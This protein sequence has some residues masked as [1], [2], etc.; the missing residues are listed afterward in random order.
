MGRDNCLV[1]GRHASNHTSRNWNCDVREKCRQLIYQDCWHKSFGHGSGRW[2]GCGNTLIIRVLTDYTV[3]GPTMTD[4]RGN[5]YVRDRTAANT[6]TTIRASIFHAVI[7]TPLQAGDTITV[8]T[9]SVAARVMVVDEF[10]SVLTPTVIDQ[11]NGASAT[12]ASPSVSVTTTN[13]NDLL[14]GFCGVEGASTDSYDDDP[15]WFSLVRTGTVGGTS[16]SNKTVNGS[17]RSVAST[18]AYP[19]QPILEAS[20]SWV[21]FVM[22]YRGA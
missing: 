14:I 16:A 18:A 3:G 6:G 5:T 11:Q 19:Y 7:G 22:A 20:A 2:R 21:G 8:T 12:S 1:Q 15:F 13:A 17:Y 9:A 4:S 10:A